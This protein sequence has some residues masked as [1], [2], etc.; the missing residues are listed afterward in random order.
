M[1]GGFYKNGVLG[2]TEI[3]PNMKAM[4]LRPLG[5]QARKLGDGCFSLV[6]L[7]CEPARLHLEPT[8]KKQVFITLLGSNYSPLR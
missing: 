5:A 7:A 3:D 6:D 8:F 4:H 2:Y 1:Q